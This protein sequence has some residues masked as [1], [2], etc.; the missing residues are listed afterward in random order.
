MSEKQIVSVRLR[1]DLISRLKRLALRF[2]VIDMRTVT[3]SELIEQSIERFVN[4][5]HK[6][7]HAQNEHVQNVQ[8][9]TDSC[10][11]GRRFDVD[12]FRTICAEIV[13]SNSVERAEKL[14]RSSCYLCRRA[15]L[16][17]CVKLASDR[18]HS[19]RE[20]LDKRSSKNEILS[21]I[22][23]AK[24]LFKED[25]ADDLLQEMCNADRDCIAKS[26]V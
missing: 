20:L 25:F 14:L 5:Q 18:F 10:I 16:I 8:D 4:T 26:D 6:N 9:A 19:Y 7:D 2:S 22:F 24:S 12:D 13:C 17:A 23:E 15:A 11:C 1:K 3:V 21:A